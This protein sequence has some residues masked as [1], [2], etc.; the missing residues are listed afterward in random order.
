MSIVSATID[1][2]YAAKAK[3]RTAELAIE[4]HTL[5]SNPANIAAADAAGAAAI[6]ACAAAS[7]TAVATGSTVL[8]VQ[9]GVEFLAPAITGSYVNGYTLTIV[10]GVVTA[11]SAS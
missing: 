4:A 5:V 6:A 7:I 3:L 2:K 9:S 1:Q 10:N 11:I 8:L